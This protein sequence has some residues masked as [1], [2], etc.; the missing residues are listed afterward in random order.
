MKIRTKEMIEGEE[1]FECFREAMKKLLSVP[2]S[3][4]PSPFKKN[5]GKKGRP[6]K[7]K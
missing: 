6:T 4:V 3:E 7:Q 5:A 1:A 2:K